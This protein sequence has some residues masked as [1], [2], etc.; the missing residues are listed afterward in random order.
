MLYLT[1]TDS[2]RVPLTICEHSR[3]IGQIHDWS[4]SHL[5]DA[6]HIFAHRGMSDLRVS[7]IDIIIN[8]TPLQVFGHA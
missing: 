7:I 3:V 6:Q 5:H 2:S 4:P 8:R 1:T